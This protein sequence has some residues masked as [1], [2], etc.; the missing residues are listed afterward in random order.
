ME[1]RQAAEGVV[2]LPQVDGIGQDHRH[3]HFVAVAVGRQLGRAGGAA[4]MEVG[5]DVTGRNHPSA[6]QVIGG[7]TVEQFVE[8]Q[9]AFR[10]WLALGL[11]GAALGFRQQVGQVDGDDGLKLRQAVTQAGH[12]VPEIGAGER[13]QGHQHPGVGRM[14]QFGDVLGLQQRVDGIDHAGRFPTPDGEMGMRQVRQQERHR[15]ARPHTQVVEGVGRLGDPRQQL[16]ISQLER[17]FFGVALEQEGHGA[18]VRMALGALTDQ[19]IGAVR[20]TALFQRKAFNFFDVAQG[21]DGRS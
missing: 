11:D 14:D 12:L 4:G 9:H 18:L 15:L 10:Q 21:G 6:L 3:G 13:R 1:Q 20:H 19:L 5:G 17:R 8:V 2:A 16:G 7:E